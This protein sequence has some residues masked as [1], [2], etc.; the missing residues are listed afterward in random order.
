MPSCQ[1]ALSAA[2]GFFESKKEFDV[3]ASSQLYL[4]FHTAK[5]H[6]SNSILALLK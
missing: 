6:S 4:L 5:E 3:N 2:P 1:I